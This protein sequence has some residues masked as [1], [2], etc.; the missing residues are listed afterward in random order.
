MIIDAEVF[1]FGSFPHLKLTFNKGLTL[2]NGPTG[3]G[4]STLCDVVPWILFGATSKNGGVDD[5]RPWTFTADT[6]G[7]LRFKSQN[8]I[9][10]VVR[11]R[12]KQN[13]L[14]YFTDGNPIKVRG[15]NLKDTQ[16]KLNEVLGL[17]SNTYLLGSYINETSITGSFYSTSAKNRR[18][19]L[20]GL[21]NLEEISTYQ[22][23]LNDLKKSSKAE[24]T[25]TTSAIDNLAATYEYLTTQKNTLL[26]K[27]SQFDKERENSKQDVSAKITKLKFS[28]KKEAEKIKESISLAHDQYKSPEI[29][30]TKIASLQSTVQHLKTQV[31]LECGAP[32]STN[33][34]LFLTRQINEI[35]LE[36]LKNSQLKSEIERL[37][38]ELAMNSKQL[39]VRTRELTESTTLN[40]ENPHT[41][42]LTNVEERMKNT[43]SRLK[44]LGKER[45]ELLTL[46]RNINTL[47][48]I[49]EET[50]ELKTK[51][52]IN[53]LQTN[54][55]K[56]LSDY[57]DLGLTV[58]LEIKG[59]DSLELQLIMNGN[60]CLFNQLSKGQRQLLKLAF[61][62]SS[63]QF[64]KEY[65]ASNINVLCIDEALDGLSDELKLKSYR[66]FEKLAL[67]YD[68]LIVVDHSVELKTFF[69]N[70]LDVSINNGESMIDEKP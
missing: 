64:V 60:N 8:E 70:K 58:L 2:V 19:I 22:E 38:R 55:N 53:Y 7:T 44:E 46:S 41:S 39:S 66:L 3:S 16:K 61:G 35:N 50:R 62:V 15:S 6:I 65:N 52:C 69:N 18:E 25:I 68:E 48:D 47:M 5:I 34:I 12:G 24:I 63:A 17:T 36:K 10:T 40:M 26:T 13:D 43:N 9:V 49:F 27:S 20:E 28:F 37:N 11:T 23:Q 42:M 31:C 59:Q 45:T 32:K 54:V 29:F 67:N 14:Y 21:V 57:F 51:S 56:I 33:E 1:N 4:K 30:D